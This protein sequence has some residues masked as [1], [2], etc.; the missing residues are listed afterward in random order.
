MA[1]S[2]VTNVTPAPT[3]ST[4]RAPSTDASGPA[5]ANPSGSSAS[6]PIQSYE[7]TRESASAGI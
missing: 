6:E 3:P 1:A 7:L 4:V 2:K 5:I